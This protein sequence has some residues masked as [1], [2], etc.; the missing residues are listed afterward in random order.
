MHRNK[1][2]KILPKHCPH[3]AEH[4]HKIALSRTIRANDNINISKRKI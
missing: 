3:H 4:L 1:I 2:L